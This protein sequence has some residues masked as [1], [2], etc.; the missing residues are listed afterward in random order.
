MEIVKLILAI[1]EVV[2]SVFLVLTIIFQ[3]GKSENLGT[4]TGAADSIIGNKAKSSTW[5]MRLS[6]LTVIAGA[7][8]MVIAFVLGILD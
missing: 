4:I 1:I 3:S 5:D 7:A 2:L 6:K 8:F